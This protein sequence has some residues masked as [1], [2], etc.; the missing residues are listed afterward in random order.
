[1][2]NTPIFTLL[3][4]LQQHNEYEHND[5]ILQA[6]RLWLPFTVLRALYSLLTL[7][8]I[9]SI[10]ALYTTDKVRS[11]TLTLSDMLN[12]FMIISSQ[13]ER[14]KTGERMEKSRMKRNEDLA[15]GAR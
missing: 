15:G 13:V 1:M 7:I 2:K 6:F 8:M 14:E 9:I 4:I 5:L 10:A 3:F 12:I 11:T